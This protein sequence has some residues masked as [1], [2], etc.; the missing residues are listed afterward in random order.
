MEKSAFFAYKYGLTTNRFYFARDIDSKINRTLQEYHD[1][2]TKNIPPDDVIFVFDEDSM[3]EWKKDTPL[4][5]Y[6]LTGTIIG[7]K[8]TLPLPEL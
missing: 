5:F 2:C 4:H 7:L 8:D 3:Q 6:D 1:E